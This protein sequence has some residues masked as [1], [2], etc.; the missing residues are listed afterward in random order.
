MTLGKRIH[1]LE[2]GDLQIK[3]DTGNW[4]VIPAD[5]AREIANAILGQPKPSTANTNTGV[6]AP[7]EEDLALANDGT[8][9]LRIRPDGILEFPTG[10]EVHYETFRD[11]LIGLAGM[12]S[13]MAE[14]LS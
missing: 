5:T 10:Q 4:F 9:F 6:F 13:K 3:V 2:S 1:L 14:S 12:I 11:A 8:E 7:N